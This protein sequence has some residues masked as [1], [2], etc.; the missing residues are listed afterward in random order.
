M[1]PWDAPQGE[2]KEKKGSQQGDGEGSSCPE[3]RG[4]L[5]DRVVNTE[6]GRAAVAA[7]A[8]RLAV[9]FPSDSR[10]RYFEPRAF[11]EAGLLSAHLLAGSNSGGTR[12]QN[13]GSLI[14]AGYQVESTV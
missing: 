3:D 14:R 9:F 4:K 13:W 8:N 1:P 5:T 11:P 2:A 6:K 10:V 7:T 12:A